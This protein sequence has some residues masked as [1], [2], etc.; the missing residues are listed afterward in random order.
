VILSLELPRMGDLMTRGVIETIHV[1][2]GSP[3]QPGTKLF[4]VRVDLGS[5]ADRD[6]P[7]VFVFRVVARE[8]GWLR[9]LCCAAGDVKAVGEQLARISTDANEPVD[10]PPG[11]TCRTIS[12][13]IVDPSLGLTS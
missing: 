8:K 1:A 13:T 10:A 9:R 5:A 2:E 11:R 3:I 6:C 4:D 12:A 7:P